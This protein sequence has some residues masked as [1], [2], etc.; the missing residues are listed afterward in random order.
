MLQCT[1][2]GLHLP[3][4]RSPEGVPDSRCRRLL[5]IELRP[6]GAFA[7]LATTHHNVFLIMRKTATPAAASKSPESRLGRPPLPP[8]QRMHPHTVYFT[9]AQWAQVQDKGHDWLR[10]LVET[11]SGAQVQ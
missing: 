6:S 4:K 7:L 5:H 8:E 9:D 3:A 11:P 2:A 1:H 10:G